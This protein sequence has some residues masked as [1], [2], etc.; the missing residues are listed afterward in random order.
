VKEEV[1]MKK[2]LMALFMMLF[3]FA[4]CSQQHNHNDA[5]SNKNELPEEV[6]VEV[7]TNPTELKP[8]EATELQAIVT[9]GKEQVKDAD[10]VK[11]EVWK[12]GEEGHQ[13]LKAKHKGKGVYT[14]ETTFPDDGIYYVVAHTTARDM[15]VM[16]KVEVKVGNAEAAAHNHDEH[17]VHGD[18]SI[19]FIAENVQANKETELMAH[20]QHDNAAL[21]GADV[22]FEIWNDASKKHEYVPAKEKGNGEYTAMTTFKAAGTYNVKV[23]VMKG[24]LHDHK[25]ETVQV[26]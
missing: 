15:H 23:H 8:H 20:I 17:H 9:Q 11:F 5:N 22:Q 13:M 7:K 4:G 6:K 10:E 3:V 1:I 21:T 18:T 16:P 2:F 25:E 14:A 26:K 24:D 12:Q 19:H